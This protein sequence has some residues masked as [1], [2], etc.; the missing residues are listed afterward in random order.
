M[1]KS[2]KEIASMEFYKKFQVPLLI[3]KIHN[4]IMVKYFIKPDA[5][6]FV[7]IIDLIFEKIIF[8]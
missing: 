6:L 1:I 4:A 5:F 7:Y 3:N 2:I 8:Y